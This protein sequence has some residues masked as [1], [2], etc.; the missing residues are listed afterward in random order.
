MRSYIPE[1]IRESVAKRAK[2]RCEYCK[3]YE[4]HSFLSFHI[5]HIISLKH[6]GESSEDNLAFACPICNLK[7]GSDIAT[8]IDDD[9]EIIRFFHPRRDEWYKH[10]DIDTSGLISAKTKI[11]SGTIKIFDL[12]HPDS[13]I[14]RKTMI[15]KGFF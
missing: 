11:G 8:F 10:F 15:A 2:Y 6:G 7:K 5:E 3:V 14:E 4:R 9:T 12:N 13:I 1:S